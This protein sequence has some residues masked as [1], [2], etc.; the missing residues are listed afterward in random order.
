MKYRVK[1]GL[2]VIPVSKSLN[3]VAK[4]HCKDQQFSLPLGL[5]NLHSWS[6]RGKW[7]SCCYTR[8]HSKSK[9]MWSKPSELTSYAS[10]G[11][12]ISVYINRKMTAE[13]AF[14]L[15][16]NSPGHNDLILNKGIWKGKEWKAFGVGLFR[17]FSN[18]WFGLEYDV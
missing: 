2:S 13:M 10:N 15:W 7:S 8:D 12:E 18:A 3:Y 14:G 11:F 1:H 9:C 16:I 5:C 4:T 6:K 17:N